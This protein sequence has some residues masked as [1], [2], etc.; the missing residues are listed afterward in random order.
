[1]VDGCSQT[2][3]DAGTLSFNFN[4]DSSGYYEA[5]EDFHLW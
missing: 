2:W 1:M 4:P 5:K 3:S